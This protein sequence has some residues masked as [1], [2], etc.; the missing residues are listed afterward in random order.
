M[1][2]YIVTWCESDDYD[3]TFNRVFVNSKGSTTGR[4]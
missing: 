3:N 1:K 4:H 2:T